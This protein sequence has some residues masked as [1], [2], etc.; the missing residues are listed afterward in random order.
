MLDF[1]NIISALYKVGLMARL[2][3][4]ERRMKL[5]DFRILISVVQA[6][7]MNKAAALLNTSQPA[8]SRAIAELEE[9]IGVRLFDRNRQG[10]EPTKY[11]RALLDCGAAVFDELRQGIQNIE[12]LADPTAGEV[13]IGS[14]IPLAA[15]YVSAVIDRVSR[16]YPRIR[17]DLVAAQQDALHRDLNERKV[18]LLIT[19][20]WGPIADERQSFEFL[21]DDSYVV[22]AGEKN[23]WARRR[24]ITFAD[25]ANEMWA[26]PPTDSVLGTVAKEAFRASG[27]DYPLATVVTMPDEVR[28]SLL[29]TGRFLTIFPTSAMNF[30]IDRPKL[31]VLPVKMPSARLPVGIITLKDRTLSPIAR[32]FIEQARE[33]AKPLA[34][35]K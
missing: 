22:V 13:R 3:R 14:V 9:A 7:S 18:D 27:I 8:I 19:W 21:Y 20:R 32:L 11:G 34:K 5:H 12:F 23:P 31:K 30:S 4:L 24:G 15:S 16:R 10:L 29:A 2:E 17:F 25:L 33:V 6:G 28:A 26:L 1:D 35:R